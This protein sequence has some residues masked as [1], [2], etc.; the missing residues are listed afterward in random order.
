MEINS[1]ESGW[2]INSKQANSCMAKKK[3]T[4]TK[5][6]G[7][8]DKWKERVS[9]LILLAE[10]M[11]EKSKK[12]KEQERVPTSSQMA[13]A[14]KDNGLIITKKVK[15]NSTIK[16]VVMSTQV[17]SVKE[18]SMD[19]V[20][21]TTRHPANNTLVNGTMINGVDL[22]NSLMLTIKLSS[23]VSGKTTN[24][25]RLRMKRKLSSLRVSSTFLLQLRN[26]LLL[27]QCLLNK[28]LVNDSNSLYFSLL[29]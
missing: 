2:K 16:K 22:E 20:N 12:E 18:S 17:S 7:K 27:L 5:V 19:S 8:M 13:I 21:T 24:L 23:V 3:I 25:N 10:S 4:L 6:N 28:L 1:L 26:Q 15:V 29:F 9:S 11:K 14:M